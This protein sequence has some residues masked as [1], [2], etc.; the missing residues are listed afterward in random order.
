[1]LCASP[2]L[3]RATP[4]P[5]TKIGGPRHRRKLVDAADGVPSRSSLPSKAS[6]DLSQ[7]EPS[8]LPVEHFRIG[9]WLVYPKENLL[10]RGGERVAVEPRIME[11]LEFLAYHAG[12]VVSSE[13]LLA[14][15]WSDIAVG[16][17]PVHK[18]IAYLRKALGDQAGTPRYIETIRK[19]GYRLIAPVTLPSGY[20]GPVAP[21]SSGWSQGSPFRGLDAFDVD[22]SGIF[23]GR[24]AAV[25]A[26]LRGLSGQWRNRCAFALLVGASGSGKT[27]LLRAGL[28]PRLASSGIDGANTVAIAQ[29]PARGPG[30]MRL[31]AALAEALIGHMSPPLLLGENV[32]DWTASFEQS[33]ERA[34]SRLAGRINAGGATGGAQAADPMLVVVIDQLEDFFPEGTDARQSAA[35][36]QMLSLLARSGCVAVIAA[37]RS[38]AYPALSDIAG[39]L[40]LKHPDGH[41]DLAPPSAAEITEI[42]RR[43]AQMAALSFES[44]PTGRLDDVLRD[45]AAAHPQCL[46]LLQHTLQQLYE[47]R[48]EGGGLSFAAY[49]AIGGLDGALRQHAEHAIASV[50]PAAQD[51]L[52]Y[53]LG[54]LVRL[55]SSGEQVGCVAAAMERFGL[56]PQRELIDT[57][58]RNRLLVGVVDQGK[59]AIVIAHEALL[60]AWPRAAGWLLESRDDLRLRARL[61]ESAARWDSE[62]R[63]RDLL[64]PSGRLLDE[65]RELS[66]RRGDLLDAPMSAL[67]ADSTRRES[68]RAWLRRG[69]IGSVCALAAIAIASGA[70]AHLARAQADRDRLRAEGMVEYVLG[71]LTDRLEPLGR[72]D[73]MDEVAGRILKD[74]RAPGQ[75]SADTRL[76]RSRV[77][78]QIGKIRIARG[79]VASADGTIAESLA[80]AR[81]LAAEHPDTPPL[82]LNL[83]ESSYWAGYLAFLRNDYDATQVHW[84]RYRSAAERASRL[85]PRDPR[86]WV[87]SSYALNTLGTLS[88]KRERHA[89]ALSLFQ[90]SEAY[91]RK[92]LRLDPDN[93][94]L[95]AD[96]ADSMS[97]SAQT[98]GRLGR[99]P[100]AQ[101]QYVRAIATIG[102]VRARAPQDAEWMH[103]EAILRTRNAQILA[104]L[105]RA[106]AAR[107]DYVAA[108][109]LLT[110]IGS[111]QPERSDWARDRLAL[112]N[113]AGELELSAGRLDDARRHFG[114]ADALVESLLRAQA[115]VQDLPRL[116]LRAVLNRAR[117]AHARAD[118]AM[119]RTGLEQ[120]QALLDAMPVP[121][122]LSQKDRV[123]RAEAAMLRGEIAAVADPARSRAALASAAQWLGESTNDDLDTA[124][125]RRRLGLLLPADA[126]AASSTSPVR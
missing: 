62:G 95:R 14:E 122:K 15:C 23:F 2:P 61:S 97:W 121:A 5:R 74:L 1:M 63:R 50:S 45:A 18:V 71:D 40:A 55:S 103:R 34:V 57:L 25:A 75:Q 77:L 7:P 117:L 56:A 90:Q 114:Q 119:A 99:W 47:R 24:N 116:R 76:N 28:I 106:G 120:V 102:E 59:P 16:D 42:I 65:A 80:L 22:A 96:L 44:G 19:R 113:S 30:A 115:T 125:A 4:A 112:H 73:L 52:P 123:L 27:S 10:T 111:D 67:I 110:K 32:D 70:L 53:L 82:L 33:P 35:Q 54:H 26:L 104:S 13:R 31:S 81:Q 94:R 48:E 92:A 126:L 38:S 41:I 100:Q 78:R 79:D 9:E 58:V 11:V 49:R 68:R 3:R 64:L 69:A 107:A 105:D 12:T 29:V 43:P 37:C 118:A 17:N 8:V 87:E 124:S 51:A 36:V 88:R 83:G 39:L 6:L 109:T 108:E 60:R 85:D 72:L 89:E 93:V 20:R 91:K 66:R 46:P 21:V 101:A 86:G 98:L 84:N